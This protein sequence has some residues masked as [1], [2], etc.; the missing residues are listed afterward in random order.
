M[1]IDSK[2]WTTFKKSNEKSHNHVE[3]VISL[4]QD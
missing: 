3:Y 1:D 4:Q 2:M